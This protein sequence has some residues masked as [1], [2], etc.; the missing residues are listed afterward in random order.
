M[1]ILITNDDGIG[2]P[3]IRR[4]AEMA[5]SLGE[6]WVVAPEN[7]CSAMSHR[8][9]L[10][11]DMRVT[12]RDFPVD[13]VRKAWSVGGTPADC[14]KAAV[15]VLLPEP[16]DL[17]FSGVNFG[18]NSGFDIAYSGTVA[19]AMEARM[20]GIPAVAFSRQAVECAEVTEECFLSVTRDILKKEMPQDGIWNVNF[21]GCPAADCR[22]VLWDRTVGRI[23]RYEDHFLV[24]EEADGSFAIREQGVPVPPEKYPAG[25]DVEALY[26]NYISVGVVRSMVL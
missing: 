5:A 26:R 11:K 21:P 9:T 22:G 25:S 12:E 17:V 18:Y 20:Y 14:V 24:R 16:P 8:I 6:V 1:R 23:Q 15:Q 19:A 10:R 3:G 13:G 7:Q 4:L 2:A